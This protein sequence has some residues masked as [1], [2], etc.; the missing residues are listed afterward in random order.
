MRL[1]LAVILILASVAGIVYYVSISDEDTAISGSVVLTD[2]NLIY[3]LGNYCE[4]MNGYRDLHRGGLVSLVNEHG[5]VI[6]E[7]ELLTGQ[8]NGHECAFSFTIAEVPRLDSYSLRVG[9]RPPVQISK[10]SLEDE[11]WSIVLTVEDL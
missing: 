6:A 9:G 10:S 3:R 4:G 1:L 11:G 2:N 8:L 7:G 5:I